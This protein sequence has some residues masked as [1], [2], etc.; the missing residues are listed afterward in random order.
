MAYVVVRFKGREVGRWPLTGA[1]SVGRSV[2][3]D[4][5][6]RDILL[7]RHH[8]QIVPYRNGWIA[9]DLGSKNGTRVGE[10]PITR[11]GLADGDVLS[12]GNTTVRFQVGRLPASHKPPPKRPADPF[13]ALSGTVADF[14]AD[15]VIPAPSAEA[16]ARAAAFPRPRPAPPDPAGYAADDLYGLMTEIASSSWDSIYAQASRPRRSIPRVPAGLARPIVPRG[17]VVATTAAGP[18]LPATSSPIT[19]VPPLVLRMPRRSE[20]AFAETLQVQSAIGTPHRPSRPALPPASVDACTDS[21]DATVAGGRKRRAEW[22][23][24]MLR[25][26][27]AIHRWVGPL[28]RAGMF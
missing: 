14:D 11:R 12:L 4:V 7:S 13:E 17:A 19:A 28:K 24:A 25:P 1:L 5:A 22:M 20:A 2:E 16:L 26:L 23:S 9:H 3:C 6:V 21:I 15:A 10:Q 18:V 8:C 27:T